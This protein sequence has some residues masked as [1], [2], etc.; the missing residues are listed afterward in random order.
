[1]SAHRWSSEGLVEKSNAIDTFEFG[2]VKGC[3]S[4]M[5]VH[6]MV[7]RDLTCRN[8]RMLGVS[9]QKPRRVISREDYSMKYGD[10]KNYRVLDCR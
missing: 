2:G 3:F 1:M 5:E 4:T 9:D 10:M 7:A 8:S 6:R